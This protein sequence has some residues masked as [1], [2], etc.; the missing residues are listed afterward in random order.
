MSGGDGIDKNTFKTGISRL[1]IED[2]MF[3]DRVFDLVDQDGSGQIEWDEFLTALSALE[4]GSND[5]KAKFCLQIY[6]LDG[7]GLVSRSDLS[8]MFLSSCMLEN[9][10]TTQDVCKAFV[11]RY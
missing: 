10:N 4:K 1:A 3:V 6:D 11:D 8:Q 2:D 7:D 5:L 9:D